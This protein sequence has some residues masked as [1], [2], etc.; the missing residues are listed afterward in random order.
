MVVFLDVSKRGYD[1]LIRGSMG[2]TL[3]THSSSV[4]VSDAN[5]AEVYALLMG[6]RELSGL[7]DYNALIE[8]DCILAMQWG[9]GEASHPWRWI[10]WVEEV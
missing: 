8:G 6:C 1:G 9:T 10:D 5:G 2:V 7:G 4:D 3:Y